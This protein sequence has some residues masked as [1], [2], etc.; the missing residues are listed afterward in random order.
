MAHPCQVEV[1]VEGD[2]IQ[3]AEEEGED[4]NLAVEGEE[5]GNLNLVEEVVV[6][7]ACRLVEEV[8]LVGPF[9]FLAVVGEEGEGVVAPQMILEVEGV[10]QGGELTTEN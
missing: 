8:E 2:L 7:V 1:G 3:V 4:L 10:A 6:V 9:H 5:G